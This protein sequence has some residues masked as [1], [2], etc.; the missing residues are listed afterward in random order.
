[1]TLYAV[2]YVYTADKA[3]LDEVR[4][5]HREYLAGLAEAGSLRGSGPFTDGAPGAL[6]VFSAPDDDA[7]AQLLA[8]DPF[9]Q[10]GVIAKTKA[11]AWNVIIG[12]WA[13][14]V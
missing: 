1:M 2:E 4:P 3:T 5:A 6:L 9:A 8:A 10:A 12:P 13:Q 11:R 7:L 14:A